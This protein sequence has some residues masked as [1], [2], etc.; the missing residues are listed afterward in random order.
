MKRVK[1]FNKRGGFHMDDT[2]GTTIEISD[3]EKARKDGTPPDSSG[4]HGRGGGPGKGAGCG[5]A[6][7]LSKGEKPRSNSLTEKHG[8]VPLKSV[9]GFNPEKE[10]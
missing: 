3:L 4:P 6:S 2:L 5:D 1:L 10:S 9:T 7:R 8:W